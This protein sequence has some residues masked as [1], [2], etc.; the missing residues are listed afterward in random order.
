MMK[1]WEWPVK[2]VAHSDIWFDLFR[3]C[4]CYVVLAFNLDDLQ[5]LK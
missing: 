5:R 1:K 4:S 3:M 2:S